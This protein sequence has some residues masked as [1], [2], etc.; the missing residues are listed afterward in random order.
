MRPNILLIYLPTV[1]QWTIDTGNFT[2]S[3]CSC[4]LKEEQAYTRLFGLW[5]FG[6][7]GTCYVFTKYKEEQKVFFVNWFTNSDTIG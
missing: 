3:E 7:G 1:K 2:N 4:F 5:P 6:Q